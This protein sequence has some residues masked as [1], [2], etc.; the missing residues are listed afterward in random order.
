MLMS[1]AH[2]QTIREE[3]SA[4]KVIFKKDGAV[5]FR[6]HYFYTHGMTA[7]AFA[8]RV[9]DD[10]RRAGFAA[11]WSAVEDRWAAWPRDS[12]FRAVGEI[13]LLEKEESMNTEQRARQRRVRI[14]Q[15]GGDDGYQWC[16]IIDGVARYSGMTR[17]EA[18][19]RR[20]RFID[21]GEM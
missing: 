1:A 10:L 21:T 6:R 5:E 15:V 17:S 13:E 2:K 8:S 12:Y 4:D 7:D 19:W 18:E 16:L 9:Q 11:R 20:K 3:V 14:R